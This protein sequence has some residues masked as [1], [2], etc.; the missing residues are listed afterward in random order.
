MP[1]RFLQADDILAP[2]VCCMWTSRYLSFVCYT[3][4]A[5]ILNFTVGNRAIQIVWKYQYSFSTS[6][7]AD[8]AY[9][10]G[11]CLI[12]ILSMVPQTYLVHW[13]GKKCTCLDTGLPY[14]ILVSL[15]TETFVRFG[16]TAVISVVILSASCYK[17]INWLLNTPAE[18]LSDTWNILALPGTTKEQMAEFSRSQGWITATLCTVP[19]SVTFLTVSIVETGY[20][21]LCALGFCTVLFSSEISRVT[22]LLLDIQMLVLPVVLAVYI[23]ALRELPVRACKA[24][25][26]LCQ[27]LCKHAWKNTAR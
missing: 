20:K 21:F 19:L 15:Y 3:F 23:P 10:G 8:L 5:L 12:S 1:P 26:S 17:I 25:S 22:S 6:L 18:Q 16:L 13:D 14:G 9:M 11:L 24:V 7:L 2:I 27:R 4:A